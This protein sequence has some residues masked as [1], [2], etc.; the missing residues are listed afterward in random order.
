MSSC[1]APLIDCADDTDTHL[2]TLEGRASKVIDLCHDYFEAT[3]PSMC[4]SR[5]EFIIA[6]SPF[7]ECSYDTEALAS[8][9]CQAVAL[10]GECNMFVAGFGGCPSLSP[11]LAAVPIRITGSAMALVYN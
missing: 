4:H 2:V 6:I 8:S 7:L 10:V 5:T 11:A 3:P 1:Y 9:R